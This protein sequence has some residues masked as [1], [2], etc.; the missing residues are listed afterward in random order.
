ME[1]VWPVTCMERFNYAF[2][3][4]FCHWADNNFWDCSVKSNVILNFH[5]ECGNKKSM[6]TT[7]WCFRAN[8]YFSTFA[9]A[10]IKQRCILL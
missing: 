4:F 10:Q 8:C 5:L 1:E 3:V 7:L 9:F 2:I 6:K